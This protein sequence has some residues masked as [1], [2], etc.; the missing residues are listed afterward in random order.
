[1]PFPGSLYG[2][3]LNNFNE[4]F[5]LM[6]PYVAA[7]A[8]NKASKISGQ[9]KVGLQGI[10]D[11]YLGACP[12]KFTYQGKEYTPKSFAASLGLNFDDYVTITTP[13]ILSTPHS[14]LRYR[15]TGAIRCH[16]TFLS[17]K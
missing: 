14:P 8:K 2:D 10:L 13:T 11:A 3:S 15:T 1:M 5:S 9:W 4:F 17:T 7:I 6:E 16:G 12:E